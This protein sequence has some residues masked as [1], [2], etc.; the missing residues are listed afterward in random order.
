MTTRHMYTLTLM[1]TDYCHSALGK[2][3]ELMK[4]FPN[5]KEQCR[6]QMYMHP[7]HSKRKQLLFSHVQN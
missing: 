5:N 1:T 3:N 7:K 6:Q 4:V 2:I